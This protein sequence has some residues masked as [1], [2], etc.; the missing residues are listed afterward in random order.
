MQHGAL[1]GAVA[2]EQHDE[3]AGAD[4][5]RDAVHHLGLAVGD[6]QVL[7]LQQHLRMALGAIV[8]SSC[9][10][11]D[12]DHFGIGAHLGRASRA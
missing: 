12:A 5:E 4:V 10:Q 8:S 1:A 7:D 2:P 6:V 9:P 3:L 11:V